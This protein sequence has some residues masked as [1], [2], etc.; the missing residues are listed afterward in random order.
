[1]D[2][3]IVAVV[4]ALLT[5]MVPVLAGVITYLWR[6]LNKLVA[7]TDNKIDD[8]LVGVVTQVDAAVRK[9]IQEGK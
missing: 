1:M 4:T 6:K 7:E 8:A 2:L 3:D 9:A 5:G